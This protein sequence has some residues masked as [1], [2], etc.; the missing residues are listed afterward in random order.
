MESS[1]KNGGV[2]VY[3]NLIGC[4]GGRLYFDGGSIVAINDKLIAQGKRFI[5]NEVEVVFATADLNEVVAYRSGIKS[6][7]IQSLQNETNIYEVKVPKLLLHN[8]DE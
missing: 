2:F 1:K 4:D 3:S 6:R 7:C 8:N 5:L